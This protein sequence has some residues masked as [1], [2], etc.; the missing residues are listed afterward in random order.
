VNTLRIES[1]VAGGRGVGRLEGRAVFIPDVAPGDLVEMRITS[2]R[3]RFLE[4]AV[5]KV[6]EA[7]PGRVEPRCRHQRQCGGCSWQHLAYPVQ[8]DAKK[9]MLED[10]LRRIGRLT[11]LP[12]TE[13]WTAEPWGYRNR[14]QFQPGIDRDG[15]FWGFF[16][17]G[18]RKALRLSEC[19]VLVRELSEAWNALPPPESSPFEDRYERVAR[20]FGWNGKR[21]L[22]VPGET[23][24]VGVT[25]LGRNLRFRSDG[26]FQS[27][28]ALLPRL[29]E[30]VMDGLDGKWA[31]DLYAGVGLFARFLEERFPQV[32]VVEPDPAAS[33]LA[34]QN[35]SKSKFHP[36]TAE[37]WL[38]RPQPIRP[39][40][41]VVDPPRQ[42]L[43]SHAL[44]GLL[45]LS[46]RKLRYV[47]C[48]HDTLA[49]DLG[50]FVREGWTLT[51]LHLFDFYPQTP[52]LESLACL[53]APAER[54]TSLNSGRW[55]GG[56][57]GA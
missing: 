44:E 49:R 11:E 43:T 30:A 51:R 1:L 8:V 53:E 21:W 20:V 36:L 28:L 24:E 35:L 9:R 29:V 50:R 12:E 22:H 40:V 34:R 2:D 55:A 4:A 56:R 14:A 31:V 47:S 57:L 7:G 38:S 3:G 23:S 10:S 54:E 41:V 19:P 33:A 39:D 46:P 13:V 52:H 45:R 27:N 32:D 15:R 37:G 25:V 18:S 48:G 17:G 42:G 26:F 16:S 5:I 6:V